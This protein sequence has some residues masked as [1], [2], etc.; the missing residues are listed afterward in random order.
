MNK[1]LSNF[2]FI[3]FISV[4]FINC[5][6]RG[7]PQGG[8]KDITPP[9]ILKSIP[10]NYSTNFNGKEIR[11]YFDEYIK[12]LED[13]YDISKITYYFASNENTS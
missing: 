4:I 1:R 5:A 13:N 8:D 12:L 7:T 2:I 9:K 11:V 10:E 3:V 6:N